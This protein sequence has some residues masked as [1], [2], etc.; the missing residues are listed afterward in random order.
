MP[1]K[2]KTIKV[3]VDK[4][5]L[6]TLGEKMYV[7]SIELLRELVNNAYDAD[8]TEV[9]VIISPD[10]IA[11]EDNG[12]GMNE[13]GLNQFFIIG[14]REKVTK[15]VSPRFGR[16][17]IG[18][19]GIGK[20]AVLSAANRFTVE[21]KKGKWLYSVIFD[22]KKWQ[23]TTSWELP[24]EKDLASPLRQDGTKVILSDLT[25]KFNLSDIERYLKESLPLRVKKFTVFLNRKRITPYYIPGKGIPID[26]NTM[27]G[28]IEGEI[29][30]AA[31]SQLVEK[32]GIE[33]RVKQVLIK[34]E[35]FGMDPSKYGAGRITGSVNCD[36]LP[37]TSARDE[38]IHD[39]P[40]YQLFYKVI[41]GKLRVVLDELQKE[42]DKRS[43]KKMSR[44]LKEV[45]DKIK[46]ALKMNPDLTPSGKIVAR[47]QKVSAGELESRGISLKPSSAEATKGKEKK[48]GEKVEEI[49]KKILSSCVKRIRFKKLGITCSIAH[50]GE[51]GPEVYS[52][53]NAI[54]INQDHPLYQKLYKKHD[55][56]ILHLLRL[57]TQ[58]II[59][60]KRLRL[61][62]LQAFEM[63]SKL[64]TDALVEK[65][66][67]G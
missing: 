23:E 49:K 20:F 5:H 3:T 47:R 14:S 36:F 42:A 53:K 26:I 50:L 6:L 35:L 22:K 64:L 8:A 32:Q 9:N 46:E 56:L 28:K 63:Q 11:V 61:S 31:S 38:F 1:K 25:R 60:M 13:K 16:K 52:I 29:V 27:Y 15:S 19:F 24:I 21:S 51:S 34:R 57:V 39:S 12:I 37:I 7:E 48:K 4:S 62:A 40:K 45:L 17:R 66:V 30:I 18:Q 59:I 65:K 58:E 33:C 2:P 43:I 44:A 41:Q 67:V 55:Q 10:K 54:Y